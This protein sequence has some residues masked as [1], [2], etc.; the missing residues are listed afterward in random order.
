MDHVEEKK[1]WAS[2]AQYSDDP[3]FIEKASHEFQSSPLRDG[4]EEGKDGFNR[5][6]FMKLMAASTALASSA[7]F[8]RPFHKILPYVNQPEEVTFGVPN[9][10][11]STCGECA[12]SCGTLVK[13]R[14]GRPIK[15]EGNPDHPMNKG[16]LCSRGQASILNLYDPDRLRNPVSMIRGSF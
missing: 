14:E 2:L 3:Q 12:S 16:G 5:R 9:F 11:A 15:I 1:Y 4:E 10:Y 8:Q 13:T 7:C 6:D